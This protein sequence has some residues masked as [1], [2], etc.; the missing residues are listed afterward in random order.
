M[1]KIIYAATPFRMENLTERICD[2][3]ERRRHFPLH[4]LLALPYRRFNY[5]RYSRDQIYKVCFGL[6]D[7]SDEL[8]IFGIGGGS[9]K[10]WLRAKEQGKPLRSFVKVFDP[11]WEEY[12]YSLEKYQT[13]YRE[14]LGEVLRLSALSV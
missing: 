9:F 7:L 11:K 5:D 10:E 1:K 4:P 12:A 2:F 14:V 13:G 8:W 3:I 6:V